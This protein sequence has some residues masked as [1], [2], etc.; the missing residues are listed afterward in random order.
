MAK[1][2][3]SFLLAIVCL[4]Q[5]FMTSL[6]LE[7]DSF[8]DKSFGNI[9]EG[10]DED[11]Q[12]SGL[13]FS[14]ALSIYRQGSTTLVIS[15]ATICDSVVVKCGFKALKIERRL[16]SSSSWTE[17]YNYGNLYFDANAYH[18]YEE[19]TVEPGY[20]YRVTCKHYAKKNLLSTQTISNTS[21][22]VTF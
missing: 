6:A 22:I 15:G 2:F 14:Y 1:R 11:I 5:L 12:A 7:N 19:H 13:I 3:L 9:Y 20:Q 4:S 8:V 16:N 10:I 21:N 18:L 17:Y